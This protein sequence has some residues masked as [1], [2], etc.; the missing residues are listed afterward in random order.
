MRRPILSLLFCFAAFVILSLTAPALPAQG[1][2]NAVTTQYYNNQRTGANLNETMLNTGNVNTLTFSKLFSLPVDGQ[3]YAQPLYVPGVN[4]RGKGVHNVLYVATQHNSV[5]AFDADIPQAPLWQVSLG[6][7][8]PIPA[9]F[10][11]RYGLY[12]DITVEAGVTSTP[13]IDLLRGALYTVAFVRDT[14]LTAAC[15]CVYHHDL[16]A[17]DLTSGDLK[18]GSPSRVN[19]SVAGTSVEAVNG[20]VQLDSK[21]HIQRA[22][23]LEVN[24]IIYMGFAGYADTQPYHG[25]LLGYDAATLQQVSVFNSTPD[26]GP[27]D[28]ATTGRSGGIWQSG[29][30]PS[31]DDAGN[32]YVVTGNG[33]FNINTGGRDYGDTILKLDPAAPQ[34]G[35]MT[36]VSTWFTPINQGAMSASDTDLGSTGA[37]LMP[38]SNTVM[39]ADKGGNIYLADQTALGGYHNPDQNMQTQLVGNNEIHSA[40][41]TWNGLIYLWPMMDT[42]KAYAYNSVTAQLNMTPQAV[43]STLL[44]ADGSPGGQISLSANGNQPGSGILWATHQMT[45]AGGSLAGILRAYDAA[46]IRVELWNSDLRSKDALGARAKFNPPMV[47]N[48]KVYVGTFSGVVQVYGALTN[49]VI[50]PLIYR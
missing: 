9:D 37:L 4:I 41:V 29:V 6:Q 31:A 47:A 15:P 22:A 12:N 35:G 40:L 8:A 5:Y 25:W 43:G 20:M 7:S 27:G 39:A 16:Y 34:V 17:L 48:G 19:A 33:D 18:F 42:L 28:P 44:G 2:G 46:N 49:Q 38:G 14:P 1:A 36:A 23:L 24:N 11:N 13:V 26:A 45:D 32:I 30:G 10:G 21:Y 50:L 3:V